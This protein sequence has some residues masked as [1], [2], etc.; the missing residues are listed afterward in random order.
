MEAKI[1]CVGLSRTGTTSLCEALNL[2]NIKTI[3]YPSSLFVHPEIL[4]K[5]LSFVP[6]KK[7]NF[8]QKLNLEAELEK[9]D[10]K[11]AENTLNEYTG[12]ADLPVPLFYKELDKKYPHSK[13]ILTIRDEEKWLSSMKWMLSDGKYLWRF[14]ELD[15]EI[16]L[17][18]YGTTTYD[19]NKLL[20][21]F[22]AHNSKVM[23]YFLG[24]GKDFLL[25]DLEKRELN[26]ESICN[27]LGLQTPNIQFPHTNSPKES[28]ALSRIKYW[29]IRRSPFYIYKSLKSRW[30]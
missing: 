26:F 9:R 30:K 3:H 8:L 18:Q 6:K 13:F 22:L 1:F 24:R 17:S 16:L 21:T 5:S 7:R 10:I 25:M 19:R 20:N 12:F 2:L 27:F 4:D 23:N 14:N 11:H 15:D 29:I 28:S